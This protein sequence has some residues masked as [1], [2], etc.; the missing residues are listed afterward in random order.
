MMGGSPA[1]GP[2]L[3]GGEAEQYPLQIKV[4]RS[5]R[6]F[7]WSVVSEKSNPGFSTVTDLDQGK[8]PTLPS[9]LQRFYREPGPWMAVT[10]ARATY[11]AKD[12][13]KLDNYFTAGAMTREF[14]DSLICMDLIR[15]Q[16][17]RGNLESKTI[18]V[19]SLVQQLFEEAGESV[20]LREM[21]GFHMA[22]QGQGFSGLHS[23]FE[24]VITVLQKVP[25]TDVDITIQR[26]AEELKNDR[27]VD[28]FVLGLL[29]KAAMHDPEHGFDLIHGEVSSYTETGD[30]ASATLTIPNKPPVP[31]R[32][33]RENDHWKIDAIGS[34]E[35]LLER[36]KQTKAWKQAESATLENTTPS[37]T[38]HDASPLPPEEPTPPEVAVPVDGATGVP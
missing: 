31:I 38:P 17:K 23:Q 10:N 26:D 1:T 37:S 2:G 36:L 13:M 11:A 34:N 32:F 4:S 21:I 14:L 30:A 7:D 22:D 35:R 6:W 33:K 15:A 29:I 25:L 3:L 20:G 8:A 19:D 24:K 12:W 5:G 18:F 9:A 28:R 27:L 16:L